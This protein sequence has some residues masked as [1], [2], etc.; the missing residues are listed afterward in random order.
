MFTISLSQLLKHRK[1]VT[2]VVHVDGMF[3]QNFRNEIDEN[4]KSCK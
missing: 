4:Q 3:C 1:V 2:S